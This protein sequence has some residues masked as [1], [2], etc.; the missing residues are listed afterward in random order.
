[1]SLINQIK[2]KYPNPRRTPLG[3]NEGYCVGGALCQWAGFTGFKRHYP[4]SAE[5]AEAIHSLNPHIP[6]ELAYGY[7]YR[8][9]DAND[10]GRFDAAWAIAEE[11]LE[12]Q[13]QEVS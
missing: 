11:A 7:S 1:M 13:P 4:L 9:M 6:I 12:Y 3:S 2:K 10:G 5:I 8:I